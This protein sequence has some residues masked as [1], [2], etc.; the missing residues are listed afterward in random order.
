MPAEDY[1]T[2]RRNALV[3]ELVSRGAI[4]SEAVEKAMRAV[5]RHELL[6]D[7]WIPS[8][9][10]SGLP[11]EMS[12]HTVEEGDASDELLATIYSDTPIVTKVTDGRAKS[13]TSQPGLVAQM[14]EFLDLQPGMRVLEIGAGTGYNAAL[15]AEIVGSQ[16]SITTIDIAPDVAE[17]AGRMLA[18]AGYP[19][20][21]VICADGALGHGTGSYDRIVA[22]VGCSDIAP[23][24][25]HQL[26]PDGFLFIPLSHFTV[27]HPLMHVN[28]VDPGHGTGRVVAPA[29]FMP[30]EGALEVPQRRGWAGV[31]HGEPRRSPV[32]AE[33]REFAAAWD[34][35]VW[36]FL[37]FLGLADDRAG[38]G[39]M[40][41]NGEG[42]VRVDLAS[43]EFVETGDS[44]RLRLELLAR[45][46]TWNELGR[47]KAG[48]WLSAF[49]PIDTSQAQEYQ[50][51][52]VHY[53]QVATLT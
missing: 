12:A 4:S 7:I 21:A 8:S 3:D 25:L 18:K 20:I 31:S 38:P 39:L 40:L 48:D 42:S 43:D 30:I 29:G 13:S 52:R 51:N 5:A 11:L 2:E 27:G 44:D 46:A 15:M 26:T 6:R 24:W 35:P 19:D 1:A 49:L 36:D 16:E 14:L 9:G 17:R 28:A 32:P 10:A 37:Y 47:P 22:T 41:A 23:A 34:G 50:I 53:S 45:L 33:I